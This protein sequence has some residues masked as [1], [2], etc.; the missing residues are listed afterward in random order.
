MRDTVSTHLIIFANRRRARN[1][2]WC[3]EVPKKAL[4][5]SAFC[6]PQSTGL[7]LQHFT[8]R[9]QRNG[10]NLKYISF[11]RYHKIRVQ[12]WFFFP[13]LIPALCFLANY[14]QPL[15]QRVNSIASLQLRDLT[16]LQPWLLQ[17]HRKACKHFSAVTATFCS[18]D[19]KTYEW[20]HWMKTKA[21]LATYYHLPGW[22][23]VGHCRRSMWQY[24][25]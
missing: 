6:I 19:I 22:S 4:G 3:P 8:M 23:A 7:Q 12:F 20:Q 11:H 9:G 18:R 5:R 17:L 2:P 14:Q 16:Q 21:H 13:H 10:E 25:S 1:F 24:F 15:W